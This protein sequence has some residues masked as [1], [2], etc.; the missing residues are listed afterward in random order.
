[1]QAVL[2]EYG[3]TASG[4][5]RAIRALWRA[6]YGEEKKAREEKRQAAEAAK[7]AAG[8]TG[9]RARRRRGRSEL[10]NFDED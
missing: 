8:P 2:T 10:A 1:M 3:W 7:E 5:R 6:M 9:G 4:E